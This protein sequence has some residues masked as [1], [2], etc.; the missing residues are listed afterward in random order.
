MKANLSKNL[1]T[2]CLLAILVAALLLCP[3]YGG[4][5]YGLEYG[6]KIAEDLWFFGEDALNLAGAQSVVNGWDKST[7]SPVIIAV[8]DTGIDL[9]HD[10]FNGVLYSENGEVV[11]FNSRTNTV[12][13]GDALADNA[14]KQRGRKRKAWQLRSWRDCYGD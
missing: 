10:L 1:M 6:D 5:S 11:G 14:K 4:V 12:V 9:S 7:L 2:V 8:A 3:I 13:K